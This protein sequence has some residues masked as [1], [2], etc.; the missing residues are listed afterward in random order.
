MCDKYIRARG[1]LMKA[2]LHLHSTMSDSSHNRKSVLEIAK[3]NGVT[4][5]SFTDHDIT[6]YAS[7][8]VELAK[9]YGI[10]AF[11]GVEISAVDT[12]SG[13]NAHILGFDYKTSHN[14]EALASKTL[15]Y[16]HK[17]G[18][19]QIGILKELGYKIEVSDIE[20]ISDS[21]YIYK[22]HILDFLART[23]Q[24]DCQF[25]DVYRNIFKNGGK[26]DFD[27]EYVEAEDA[28][29]AII[30]D[31]GVACLAHAGQQ[32]LFD[33]V[34]KFVDFGLSAIEV[35]HPSHTEEDMRK[36]RELAEK[37]KLYISGGSDFHGSYEQR[38]SEVGGYTASE[39]FVEFLLNR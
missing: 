7:E 34:A 6:K 36:T 17:N 13:K 21:G 30:A 14:I 35:E 18:L 37:H 23:K 3:T 11:K 15:N 19:R 32:K 8:G 1:D 25:G 22:Q 31:G 20:K 2:D 24:T 12:Q 38:I 4:H 28:I 10:H 5:I 16:R 27:I 26:C 9:T 39:A 33:E 29:K